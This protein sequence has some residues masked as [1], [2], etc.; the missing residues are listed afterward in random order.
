MK[1]VFLS[2]LLVCALLVSSCEDRVTQH[3][4]KSFFIH[5]TSFTI[6]GE[7][8]VNDRLTEKAEFSRIVVRTNAAEDW[9]IEGVKKEG[10]KFELLVDVAANGITLSSE[11]ITPGVGRLFETASL[12]QKGLPPDFSR[13][14][15]NF[16]VDVRSAKGAIE[17]EFG[18][19]YC[20]VYIPEAIDLSGEERDTTI[21]FG[22]DIYEYY[23]DLNFSQ[24]GWYKVYHSENKPIGNKASYSSGANTKIRTPK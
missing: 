3:Y 12:L 10:N 7:V 18:D 21:G 14:V 8:F 11:T 5:E 17:P 1:P 13:C 16:Y 2:I 24:P 6:E 4:Y 20:Y 9:E 19:Y 23:Y 22:T 15:L